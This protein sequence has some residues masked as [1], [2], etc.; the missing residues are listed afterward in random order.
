MP[1][2][3][4]DA[5]DTNL[6]HQAPPEITVNVTKHEETGLLVCAEGHEP[7][8]VL[9]HQ[10]S[11]HMLTRH[12]RYS[13]EKPGSCEIRAKVLQV[14]NTGTVNKVPP[15]IQTELP[16][17]PVTTAYYCHHCDKVTAKKGHATTERCTSVQVK[18]QI[19]AQDQ[20]VVIGLIPQKPQV[21]GIKDVSDSD[22]EVEMLKIE[23]HQETGLFVCAE[24][25]EPMV[26]FPHQFQTHIKRNHLGE[27][28][29]SARLQA[30]ISKIYSTCSVTE[31]LPSIRTPFPL[32]PLV[33]GKYCF[34]CRRVYETFFYHT[35]EGKCGDNSQVPV[36][37]QVLQDLKVAV[38]VGSVPKDPNDN[39]DDGNL[40]DKPT[41]AIS[42]SSTKL[43]DNCPPLICRAPECGEWILCD[44]C[45]QR[46]HRPC[47]GVDPQ[48]VAELVAYHCSRCEVDHGPLVSDRK[49]KRSKPNIDYQALNRGDTFVVDEPHPHVSQ[50]M[51]FENQMD[52]AMT[53]F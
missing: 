19:Y 26:V 32:I 3:F 51:A 22:I 21:E 13:D 17:I 48:L 46:F 2:A 8:V 49:S 45:R 18:C 53:W 23:K 20:Y 14:L 47:V 15:T 1:D 25:H 10:I 36:I 9:P 43:L 42:G 6:H 40:I 38:V 30:E 52:A 35:G 11:Q 39:R 31:V 29:W 5:D 27:R 28:G 37:F 34:G 12:S 50:V 41:P 16:A 7:M 44:V 24:G 4:N 33:Q